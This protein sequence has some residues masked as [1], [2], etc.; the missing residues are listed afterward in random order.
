MF[1]LVMAL[2]MATGTA[3]ADTPGNEEKVCYKKIACVTIK[4]RTVKRA[5]QADAA[6]LPKVVEYKPIV[7]EHVYEREVV[8]YKN[9]VYIFA[10]RTFI[11]TETSVSGNT[12]KV[13]SV[14]AVVPG[15]GYMRHTEDGVAL[16]IAIDY[17]KN[18]QMSA[19]LDF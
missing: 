3:F 9:T 16:G 6:V 12:A 11:G 18:V 10:H 8:K 17:L 5:K 4:K 7:V 2:T 15:I 19:G 1:K 13:D 14:T